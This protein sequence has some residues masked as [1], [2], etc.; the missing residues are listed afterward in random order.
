MAIPSTLSTAIPKSRSRTPVFSGAAS[1]SEHYW[2]PTARHT[3]DDAVQ[4]VVAG[5]V[6]PA[7]SPG[8]PR[9]VE[10]G[11]AVGRVL[12]PQTRRSARAGRDRAVRLL[13]WRDSRARRGQWRLRLAD[14]RYRT[15]PYCPRSRLGVDLGSPDRGDRAHRGGDFV[16]AGRSGSH[17]ATRGPVSPRGAEGRAWGAGGRAIGVRR[18]VL[19]HGGDRRP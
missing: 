2:A 10:R 8:G 5:R 1:G 6:A 16:P 14:P 19:I 11:A 9:R 17:T 15:L 18:G 12:A 13:R 7:A 4:F 3:A